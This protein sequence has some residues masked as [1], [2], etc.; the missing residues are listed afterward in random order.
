MKKNLN[1]II[2]IIIINLLKNIKIK[3]EI[4]ITNKLQKKSKNTQKNL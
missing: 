2:Q 1:N 3:K 4:K